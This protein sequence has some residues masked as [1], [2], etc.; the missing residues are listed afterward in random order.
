MK[1]LSLRLPRP[2]R[3]GKSLGRRTLGT[4]L[5]SLGCGWPVYADALSA[6]A[7]FS[8]LD[9]PGLQ[10]TASQSML[11]SAVPLR[12]RAFT[13]PGEPVQLA[14]L[15]SGKP[16]YFQRILF[17]TGRIV[18]SGLRN[19]E[20]WLADMHPTATGTGGKLSVMRV[21]QDQDASHRDPPLFF[22]WLPAQARALFSRQDL[23]DASPGK[24]GVVG[25]HV[26]SVAMPGPD[27]TAYVRRQLRSDGWLEE[28]V[29][30]DMA[31][32]SSWR[33]KTSRLALF[34]S[35]EPG[36]KS[37]LYVHHVK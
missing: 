10:W 15:Y 17:S 18:L 6:S 1:I 7:S 19:G 5:M 29:Y 20:H 8:E 27:V 28:P 4:C 36:G 25:Q 33:R 12:V 26:F 30:A 3:A 16:A 32:H 9:V 35:Q 34:S 14:Q 22:R 31:G 11:L 13:F 2:I 37:S 21:A 24:D 23:S